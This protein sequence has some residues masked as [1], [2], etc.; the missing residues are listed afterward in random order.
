MKKL[1]MFLVILFILVS[2]LLAQDDCEDLPKPITG[3]LVNDFY[4]AIGDNSELNI[5]ELLRK[6]NDS[7]SIEIAV[8]TLKDI[9]S[10]YESSY[11]TK[12][13][14]CWG[15]GKEKYNNG[16]VLLVSFEGERKWA[17]AT[18]KGIEQYLTDYTASS[19]GQENLIPNLQKGDIDE[20][21]KSTV[22]AIIKHLGWKSWEIREYWTKWDEESYQLKRSYNHQA[23]SRGFGIFFTWLLYLSLL[24]FIGWCIWNWSKEIKI[25]GEIKSSIRKWDKEISQLKPIVLDETYPKWVLRELNLL[26]QKDKASRKN[27][28]ENKSAVLKGM[29]DNP[30]KALNSLLPLLS[31]D[32]KWITVKLPDAIK[33]LK[34][35]K[36]FYEREALPRIG[37]VKEL[38]DN[39][40]ETI[41]EYINK[42]FLFSSYLSEL[43]SQ[44][45]V[46]QSWEKK[47]TQD[48]PDPDSFKR[49]HEEAVLSEGIIN[50]ILNEAKLNLKFHDEVSSE[51][52]SLYKK[53]DLLKNSD[54]KKYSKILN[55][56]KKE[57]PETVW[58]K[59]EE[60]FLKVDNALAEA[61]SSLKKAFEKNEVLKVDSLKEAHKIYSDAIAL[62]SFVESTYIS[63][64]GTQKEQA[65]AKRE[66][67]TLRSSAKSALEDAVEKCK[68][69]HVKSNAKSLKEEAVD[70]MKK[71][72]NM[73]SLGIVD[74]VWLVALLVSIK[75]IAKRSY[76]QAS[77]D[78]SSYNYYT[79]ESHHSDN[80]PTH[81][82]DFGGFGGGSFGGGGAGGHW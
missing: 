36:A 14:N 76:S 39:S 52:K 26:K 78:I 71:A 7:T 75:E 27:Y 49:S 41:N 55:E 15:V 8:V 9:S 16:I 11:A 30:E 43:I 65:N 79:S 62:I 56:M 23:T 61:G 6:Y 42:G 82:S 18:G 38:A 69:E 54:K 35:K 1:F 46:L 59:L 58:N 4:G 10:E 73:L 50:S 17:I 44:T 74:W 28:A 77:D 32:Y 45:D 51:S 12:I 57:N 68:K 63:I 2:K 21:F 67:E 20:A 60:D 5:E 3:K 40:Q 47:L 81:S 31:E 25:R 66:Y 34:E 48:N 33:E 80:S 72:E 13:G 22:N 19:I 64:E 53:I 29:K 37:E 70:K 24:S